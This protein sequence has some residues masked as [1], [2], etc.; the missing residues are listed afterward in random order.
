MKRRKWLVPLF[1]LIIVFVLQ[2]TPILA[3]GTPPPSTPAPD[4]INGTMLSRG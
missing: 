4:M 3:G 2:V 1:M